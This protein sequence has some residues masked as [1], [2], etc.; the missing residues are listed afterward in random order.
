MKNINYD[1]LKLLHTK[2]DTVW[3]LEKHYIEDAEKVQCH[4]IDAMKQMLEN[5]KKHIE[6]LNAEIKMRMDVGEWN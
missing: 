1:L 5:D 2:L 4:S 3:R 6:M